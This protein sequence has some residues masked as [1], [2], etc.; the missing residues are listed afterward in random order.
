LR[1][2]TGKTAE[3]WVK[4]GES[5]AERCRGAARPLSACVAAP[6]SLK[7]GLD[8]IAATLQLYCYVLSINKS[9]P[10]TFASPLPTTKLAI[11]PLPH[12]SFTNRRC[13]LIGR[14]NRRRS[15]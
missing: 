6:E 13:N 7:T 1:S 9:T 11:F 15:L 14:L 10:S 4:P 2:K 8:P 5:D 3:L 12:S